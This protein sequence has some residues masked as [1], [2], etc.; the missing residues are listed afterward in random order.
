[1]QEN[2]NNGTFSQHA[3]QNGTL[4]GLLWCVMYLSFIAGFTNIFYSFLFLALNIASP[5]FAGYLAIAY[6]KRFCE[7]QLTY[8]KSLVFLF[9]MYVCAALLSAVMQTI[10]FSFFD[11]GYFIQTMQQMTGFL[12][13]S[14]EISDEMLQQL[15][16][17]IESLTQLGT[18]EIVIN[19]LSSNIMNSAIITPIIALFVKRNPK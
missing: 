3:M 7:N 12:K 9:I 10:Y 16:I 4:L 13:E 14:P 2:N 17:A 15:S 11:N 6:R 5:F 18:K 1:M 8:Y 19:F